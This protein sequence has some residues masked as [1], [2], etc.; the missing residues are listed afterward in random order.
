[1][2][3]SFRGVS[4]LF[5]VGLLIAS[6]SRLEEPYESKSTTLSSKEDAKV[7]KIETLLADMGGWYLKLD[8][9]RSKEEQLLSLDYEVLKSKLIHANQELRDNKVSGLENY[10]G[11]E[12][13]AWDLYNRVERVEYPSTDNMFLLKTIRS[14]EEIKNGPIQVELPSKEITGQLTF[15]LKVRKDGA[16]SYVRYDPESITMQQVSFIQS[17]FGFILWMQGG[18]WTVKWLNSHMLS[19]LVSGYY[20]IPSDEGMGYTLMHKAYLHAV[21]YIDSWYTTS[22]SMKIYGKIERTGIMP[23]YGIMHPLPRK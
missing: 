11:Q 16:Y 8:S 20:V 15:T 6:C 3:R 7:K 14:I 17:G 19:I 9:T 22:G 4:I 23:K 12:A 1:M 18:G 21:L 10:S 5:L 13:R 2:K